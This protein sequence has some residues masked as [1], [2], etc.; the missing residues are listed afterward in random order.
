MQQYVLRTQGITVGSDCM[1]EFKIQI[2]MGW[3]LTEKD[4][5]SKNQF[6]CQLYS[7]TVCILSIMRTLKIIQ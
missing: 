3:K 7:Y 6:T 4:E 2:N 5:T 1:A